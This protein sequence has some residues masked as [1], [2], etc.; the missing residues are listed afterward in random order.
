MTRSIKIWALFFFF[1]LN[2]V[3]AQVII[4][5]ISQGL[6]ATGSGRAEYVELI[7]VGT[8]NCTSVYCADI[9]GW[10]IDDNNG[11][12]GTNGIT[13]GCLRFSDDAQWQCVKPGS[14]IVIYNNVDRNPQIPP[15][16]ST[17]INND[18]VYIL[19]SSSSLLEKNP[20]FP[21]SANSAYPST[22]FTN[23]TSIGSDQVMIFNNS[24]DCC[25]IINPNG[26]SQYQAI[27]WGTSVINYNVFFGGNT[28]NKVMYLKNYQNKSDPFI[29]NNWSIGNAGVDE[30]PGAP[31]TANNAIYINKLR[32]NNITYIPLGANISFTNPSCNGVC[33]GVINVAGTNSYGNYTY[34]WSTTPVSYT[35][36]VSNLCAGSYKV[37]IKDASDCL[38][39]TI[40]KLTDSVF[41]ISVIPNNAT[42]CSGQSQILTA[43]GANT[44]QWLP[45]SNISSTNGS[46]VTVSPINNTQYTVIG[47]KLNCT[48]SIIVNIN[49]SSKPIISVD[50]LIEVCSGNSKTIQATGANNY[51]WFSNAGILST[52]GSSVVVSPTVATNYTV[53]GYIGSCS[54]TAIVRSVVNNIPSITVSG[55]NSLCRGETSVFLANGANT[56]TWAPATG[57]S[58]PF[59]ANPTVT[60]N[61][62]VNYSVIGYNGI[63]SD[64]AYINLSVSPSPNLQFSGDT[65][66]CTGEQVTYQATGALTYSWL[67]SSSISSSTDSII[68][69]FPSQT[70]IYTLIGSINSCK[71]TIFIKTLV[72]EKAKIMAQGAIFCLGD[73]A[74]LTAGGAANY[75]WQPTTGLNLSNTSNPLCQVSATTVYTLTG[76]NEC[77]NTEDTVLVTVNVNPNPQI[78]IKASLYEGCLPLSV[79]FNS[80]TLNQA[81]CKWNFNNTFFA[82]SFDT[83]IT[84]T[85]GDTINLNFWVKDNNGCTNDTLIENFIQLYESPTANFNFNPSATVSVFSPILDLINTSVNAT[86]YKWYLLNETTSTLASPLINITDTGTYLIT[87]VAFKGTCSDSMSKELKIVDETL[88]FIPNSFSPN[89]DN[90]NETFTPVIRG[91]NKN[92]DYSFKIFDRWGNVFFSSKDYPKGWNGKNDTKIAPQDIYI[93]N[94]LFYDLQNNKREYRGAFTLFR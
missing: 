62:S 92:L 20:T 36:T 2:K 30:T 91:I 81:E 3:E 41:S 59:T 7:V 1:L 47:K 43:G 25:K 44:Y 65:I 53:I 80:L 89:E 32:T 33:D 17:D 46:S 45:N 74:Y 63:C 4:N 94:L 28:Q 58:N 9:R 93:Y 37:T 31:N 84:F 57:L 14:I 5:E 10:V 72:S 61:S 66:F 22:G 35:S 15:D 49:V 21:N 6:P 79:N 75:T 82:N 39:D 23:S 26:N 50:T 71:D 19:S 13:P 90:L 68:S 64:T 40:I 51:T 85:S 24:E 54:D 42:I 88:V 12:H 70:I 69:V 55:V 78:D 76:N 60:A 11:S 48:D 8:P 38:L 52:S 83:S 86:D 27:G 29:Q 87:L 18:Y 77:P 67:P 56:Y 73:S 16:D 34:T